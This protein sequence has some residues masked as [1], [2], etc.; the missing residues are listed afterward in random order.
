[1]RL[2]P[3]DIRKQEFKRGMRGYDAD[4]VQSFLD[5][6]AEQWQEV[7]D[8]VRKLEDRVLEQDTKLQHYRQVEVALQEA[9]KTARDNARQALETAQAKARSIIESANEKAENMTRKGHVQRQQAREELVRLMSKRQ[10]LVARLKAFLSSEIEMLKHFESESQVDFGPSLMDDETDADETYV[11]ES[12]T[13]DPAPQ[14][15][16]RQAP[17]VDYGYTG[18]GRGSGATPEEHGEDVAADDELFFAHDADDHAPA[19]GMSDDD[20]PGFIVAGEEDVQEGSV[21]DMADEADVTPIKSRSD[22]A[23]F[24]ASSEEIDRIRQ[25]LDDLD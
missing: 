9:V 6:L 25:I 13:N 20:L 4:D 14:A 2:T 21:L 11:S 15:E 5:M 3:L 8:D 22:G 16:A 1:M 19:D 24:D 23:R 10:E 12:G 18:N 17:V 7:T